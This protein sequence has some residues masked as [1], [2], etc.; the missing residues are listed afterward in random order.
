VLLPGPSFPHGSSALSVREPDCKNRVALW[1]SPAE[2]DKSAHPAA[3]ELG[4]SAVSK[5]AR[6]AVDSVAFPAA[7]SVDHAR[8]ID[9]AVMWLFR[10]A[11]AAHSIAAVGD[12]VTNYFVQQAAGRRMTRMHQVLPAE[13]CLDGLSR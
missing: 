13:Q 2:P 10:F 9:F 8:H 4:R 11:F 7:E 1:V 12:S 3:F 6:R 5:L